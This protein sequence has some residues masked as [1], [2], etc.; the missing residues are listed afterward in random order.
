MT[1]HLWSAGQEHGPY[2]LAQLVARRDEGHWP[3][4]AYWRRHDDESW[5]P[6]TAIDAER[7]A[8]SLRQKRAEDQAAA[9]SDQSNR[10]A[11]RGWDMATWS[12][13]GAILFAIGFCGAIFLIFAAFGSSDKIEG[14]VIALAAAL[15]GLVG[16]MGILFQL[17]TKLAVIAHR[18]RK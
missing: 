4:G 18:L 1:Y 15:S 9:L 17:N 11:D 12:V 10:P 13:F 14:I 5:Q 6:V 8:D 2:T 16:V 3:E 7:I